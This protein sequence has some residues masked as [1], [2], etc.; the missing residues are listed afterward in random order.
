MQAVAN[1]VIRSDEGTTINSHD[2]RY[3]ALMIQEQLTGRTTDLRNKI[4]AQ[5]RTCKPSLAK[6]SKVLPHDLL[7][8]V[9]TALSSIHSAT[10]TEINE[11]IYSTGLVI[12]TLLGQDKV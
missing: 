4:I 11:L 6:L 3:Q 8:D 12:I 5:M 10:I 7:V 2:I 9:N 1:K